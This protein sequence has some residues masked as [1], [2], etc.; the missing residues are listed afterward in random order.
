[1]DTSNPLGAARHE[2]VFRALN[3]AM[4]RLAEASPGDHFVVCECADLECVG[5]VGIDLQNYLDVREHPRRFVVLA[6]HVVTEIERVV[7]RNDGCAIVEKNRE[8][9]DLAEATHRPGS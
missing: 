3:E 8:I 4:R 5:V 1:V 9:S 2:A 6:D 7:A